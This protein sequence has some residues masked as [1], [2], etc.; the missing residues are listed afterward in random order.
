[1][2]QLYKTLPKI[3]SLFGVAS[4]GLPL[5]LCSCENGPCGCC[6]CCPFVMEAAAAAREL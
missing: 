6:C 5:Q 4:S 2:R 1:M 3:E